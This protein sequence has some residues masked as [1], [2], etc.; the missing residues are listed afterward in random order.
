MKKIYINILLLFVSGALCAQ[1]DRSKMPE[2]GPAPKIDLGETKSFTLDNGLKVFVVENHKLPRLAISIQFDIDPILEGEKMGSIDMAGDLMAKGTS[3]MT[4]DELNFAVDYIGASF[5]TSATSVYGASLKKHQTKLLEIISDAIKNSQFKE[6]ELEKLK[7][8]YISGI[9]TEKDDPDA[10][11][12]NIRRV[13]LYGKDHPY[14]EMMTEETVNNVTLADAKAYYDTYI[15]P[16]VAYMAI[17]GDVTEKEMK[18]LIEKYFGDWK[19]GEVPSHE[20]KLK[21]QPNAPEVVFVNKPG[22]VQ[23]VISVTNTIDLKPGSEDAIKANVTNGILGGG[24]V[25]KLNLNLREAHSYT[26]GARSSISSDERV[27][28]FNATAKVRNEVTDSALTETIKELMNMRNG[29]VTEDELQTIKNYGTGTF[30]I[31]LE[32]PQ[33]K[34]TYAINI[35]KYDLDK[36]YYANYLKEVAAVTLEDVTEVSKKYIQPMNGYILVVG[37]QEEV[38]EKLKQFSPSGTITYLDSYGNKA[39]KT[40]LKAAPKGM[41]AQKVVQSYIDAIGGKKAYDKIKSMKTQMSM[42][43]QGMPLNITVITEKPNNFMSDMEMNGMSVMKQVYNGKEGKVSGMQGNKVLDEK[44]LAKME[45]ESQLVPEFLYTTESFKLDLKGL[46]RKNDEEVY[47]VEVVKPTGDVMTNY[48]SVETGLLVM[49]I[50][51]EEAQGQTFIS[52]S[53]YSD[54]REVK[55]LKVPYR[56]LKSVGPQKMDI[57]VTAVEANPKIEKGTFDVS[58]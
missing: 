17:V 58:E 39:E 57:T 19:K 32:N 20:Y 38:A 54:Y 48:Y 44:E 30:A 46:D 52:E 35:E 11:A 2:P 33:T 51:T 40:K 24:F 49:S 29:K 37:N 14:G 4:K 3:N 25:S 31:G 43:M 55:G 7:K 18:P 47:V 23:S 41:T 42:T 26:Y 28:S 8:Q 13:L 45:V 15:K 6:E 10:I 36:D 9:Q 21:T 5:Y 53:L 16:N 1:V 22:A 50:Q 56:I 27:G 34:A 12:R